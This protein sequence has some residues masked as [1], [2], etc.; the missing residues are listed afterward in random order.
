MNHAV[1]AKKNST[2]TMAPPEGLRKL[3]SLGGAVTVAATAAA[4]DAP[5][6]ANGNYVQLEH[7][8]QNSAIVW[9]WLLTREAI[10][11][12]SIRNEP[13]NYQLAELKLLR[14]F[15]DAAKPYR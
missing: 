6:I 5:G 13:T 14:C 9:T 11:R 3:I 1:V 15:S 2:T 4:A 8:I 7:P 10:E 12:T